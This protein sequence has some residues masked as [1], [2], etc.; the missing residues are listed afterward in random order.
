MHAGQINVGDILGPGQIWHNYETSVLL[1][2][3]KVNTINSTFAG[4]YGI[5]SDGTISKF[6]FRGEF[7]PNGITIG[8]V[9]SYWNEYVN[10]HALGAWA[11]YARIDLATRRAILSLTRII[12]HQDSYNTTTGYD[13][14]VLEPK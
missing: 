11:G 2:V 10:D 5:V 6:P 14:F 13:T 7:D 8:W 3:D 9:V 1:A 12:A 4:T